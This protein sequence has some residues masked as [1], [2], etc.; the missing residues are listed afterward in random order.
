MNEDLG[1]VPF[2]ERD[3]GAPEGFPAD[4]Y[5][6][7]F[8]QGDGT[9]AVEITLPAETVERAVLCGARLSLWLSLDGRLV[10]DGEGLGDEVLE[11]ASAAGPI[12]KQTLLSLVAA[13]L[14]PNYLDGEDD[15]L[16]DLKSLRGQL[17]D[18]LV[19]VDQAI[20]RLKPR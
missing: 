18:A 14:D 8:R 3:Q 9:N 10:L 13:S 1:L 5:T 7:G 6:A 2:C 15:P 17:V 16:N 4:Q 12:G 19:Q 11:A 20:E